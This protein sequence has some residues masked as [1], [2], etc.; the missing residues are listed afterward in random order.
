PAAVPVDVENAQV[1]LYG[2]MD[3]ATFSNLGI[4]GK[5][6]QSGTVT[7]TNSFS[8]LGYQGLTVYFEA[9]YGSGTDVTISNVVALSFALPGS[10]TEPSGGS[11]GGQSGTGG[12]GSSSSSG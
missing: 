8:D 7:L 11:T 12:S 4:S 9:V 5:T 3:G 1:T 10:T 6:G 2:S